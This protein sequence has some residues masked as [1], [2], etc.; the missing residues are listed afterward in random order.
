MISISPPASL[1][2]MAEVPH[3]AC[4]VQIASDQT[5]DPARAAVD[6]DQLD[7]QSVFLVKSRFLGDPIRGRRARRIRDVGEANLFSRGE[8]TRTKDQREKHS[9]NGN[10][11]FSFF[12]IPPR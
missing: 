9:E 5:L 6:K 8:C 4:K 2:L 12:H 10:P 7:V 11:D 3:G 1:P